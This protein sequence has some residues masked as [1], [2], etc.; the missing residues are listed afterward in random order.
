M[1]IWI[2]II[3]ILFCPFNLP[4]LQLSSRA[5]YFFLLLLLEFITYCEIAL[6]FLVDTWLTN[7]DNLFMLCYFSFI[8]WQP[9]SYPKKII[10]C[11]FCYWIS[12]VSLKHIISQSGR[13][14]AWTSCS[15][16]V[17]AEHV[18]FCLF[19]WWP[20][21]FSFVLFYFFLKT[22]LWLARNIIIW[23][24]LIAS[25]NPRVEGMQTLQ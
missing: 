5:T 24:S 2:H 12:L 9:F 1:M 11:C 13:Y 6:N 7:A 20:S 17:M 8:V 18:F 23:E 19:W 4:V 15:V 25:L 22:M 21:M 14:L 16:L 10:S 3:I